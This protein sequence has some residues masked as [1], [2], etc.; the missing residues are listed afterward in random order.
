MAVLLTCPNCGQRD[1]LEYRFGGETVISPAKDA[2]AQD[3]LHYSYMRTNA[4]GEQQEWW[5]HK[6]GCR[7]WFL[8]LRD[9]TTNVDSKTYWPQNIQA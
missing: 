2:S 6:F 8:A 9:R 7:K 5:Y 4:E 1:I 3:W